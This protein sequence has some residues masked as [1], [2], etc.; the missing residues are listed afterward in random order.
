MSQENVE[1]IEQAIR[2]FNDDPASEAALSLLDPDVAWEENSPF[3]PGLAPIYRGRDGYLRWLKQ[4]VIEP[5]E[6][7]KIITDRLE[8]LRDQV[9]ACIR[10]RA[11]GRG[12]GVQ[13]E[14]QIFQLVTL[15]DGKLARRRIYHTRAEALEAAGLSE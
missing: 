13:V 11:K 2:F 4:A 5:F 14:M 9:L 1:V 10:L 6:E 3:Y 8:N 7:F 12:S 15:R